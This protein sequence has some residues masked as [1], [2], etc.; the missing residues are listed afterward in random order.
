MKI[1]VVEKVPEMNAA[2]RAKHGFGPETTWAGFSKKYTVELPT[3]LATRIVRNGFVSDTFST[4]AGAEVS[5]LVLDPVDYQR[6]HVNPRTDLMG[7]KQRAIQKLQD[8]DKDVLVA[9]GWIGT[10]FDSVSM[11][12]RESTRYMFASDDEYLQVNV[13]WATGNK[14]QEEEARLVMAYG[15]WYLKIV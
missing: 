12:N 4:P 9:N 15:L 3:N 11:R 14:R 2:Y 7:R 6:Q 1:H 13:R 8:G 5:F 10:V